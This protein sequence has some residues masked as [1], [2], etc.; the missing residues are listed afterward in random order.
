M[1]IFRA[2]AYVFFMVLW[3]IRYPKVEF[4]MYDRVDRLYSWK[5]WVNPNG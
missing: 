2:L 3:Q 1:I 4:G 5:G